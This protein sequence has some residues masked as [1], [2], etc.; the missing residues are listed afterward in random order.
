M[1]YSMLPSGASAEL[2]KKVPSLAAQ[3]S[4]NIDRLNQPVAI[5]STAVADAYNT[6]VRNWPGGAKKDVRLI[7]E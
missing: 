4:I 1:I 6:A 5:D 2:S 7:T 3:S